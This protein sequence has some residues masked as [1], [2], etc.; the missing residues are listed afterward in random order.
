[1]IGKTF[2][3][4]LIPRY[5]GKAVQAASMKLKRKY[6]KYADLHNK[7]VTVLGPHLQSTT[8]DSY[9]IALVDDGDDYWFTLD[10]RY[11][12]PIKINTACNCPTKTLMCQGCQCGA[13]TREKNKQEDEEDIKSYNGPW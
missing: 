5:F 2:R 8:K 7:K 3:V 1:M 10:K 6:P 9:R 12:V 13:F 11:L 4:K